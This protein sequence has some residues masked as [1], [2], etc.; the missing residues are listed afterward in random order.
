MPKTRSAAL[1]LLRAVT[2]GPE[3]FGPGFGRR[4]PYESDPADWPVLG[5]DCVW[6]QQA[7][8]G[9]VLGSLSRYGRLPA[10][11]GKGE[12]HTAATVTLHRTAQQ[13]GWEIA[14]TL[15]EALRCP[16]Q[17]LRDTERITQLDSAGSGYDTN[18]N[19][20][21]DDVVMELG[22]YFNPALAGGALYYAW[23][24]ARLGPV[25]IA[26]AVEGG[27][28]YTRNDLMTVAAQAVADMETKVRN[29]LGVQK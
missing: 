3:S 23:Y 20:S 28:G 24:Q 10:T 15:E 7:L 26:V 21:A 8:P 1:E 25:T 22:N 18:D 9:D 27:K 12:V 11:G 2:A 5:T 29:A 4:T 6:Q 17:Q 14:E 13:A 16:D 19:L